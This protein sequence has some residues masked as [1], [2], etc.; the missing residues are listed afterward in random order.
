M[1]PPFKEDAALKICKL[2]SRALDLG[3]LELRAV[4]SSRSAT[5][6]TLGGIMLGA[7]LMS[8]EK[9]RKRI[10]KVFV[11]TILVYLL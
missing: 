10:I 4:D 9:S 8:D 6:R 7:M 5:E 3:L 2:L 1:F 11:F